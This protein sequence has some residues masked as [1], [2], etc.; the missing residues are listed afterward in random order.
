MN[1]Q[2]G[3]IAVSE[4]PILF[5]G[6]MV[7]AILEGRK[8]QTRR[9]VNPQPYPSNSNPPRCKDTEPGD[10]FICP[11]LFPTEMRD[12]QFIRRNVIA[13]CTAIG[14]YHCMGVEQFVEK[15]CPYG[16][17]GD[18]LWVRDAFW[19]RRDH[20]PTVKDLNA[21]RYDADL[22][23]DDS[24]CRPGWAE[25]SVM[26]PSIHMPRWASRITLEIAK[27]RVERVQQITGADAIEE[28]IERGEYLGKPEYKLY[29]EFAKLGDRGQWT[30]DP[31]YSY[32]TL[33]DS[34][35]SKRGYGWDKNPWVWVVE[36]KRIAERT[37]L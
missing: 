5:P 11:D 16:K 22:S 23:Q 26:R 29:G 2:G 32:L 36:F 37:T 34:I 19:E 8:T 33:W 21:I 9:V 28:G 25:T 20:I 17:P 18:R 3:A 30:R 4:K 7:R 10:F 6:A 14:N 31:R 15:H 13:H 35:N 1:E 24:D 27:V 12:G